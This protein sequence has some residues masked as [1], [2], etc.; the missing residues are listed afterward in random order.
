MTVKGMSKR[1]TLTTDTF[2][3]KGSGEAYDAVSK[4]CGL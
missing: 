4:E 3:L 2:S 1:G